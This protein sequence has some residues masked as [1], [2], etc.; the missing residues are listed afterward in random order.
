MLLAAFCAAG[1]SQ[2]DVPAGTT[3]TVAFVGSEVCADCHEQAYSAWQGSH[4]QL[5]MQA[6]T[7]ATVRG[8]FDDAEVQYFGETARFYR[9]DGKFFV[10]AQDASGNPGE[11]EVRWVFGLYPLEQYLVEFPGGRLQA[12]PWAWDTRSGDDGGQRWFHL[13]PDEYIEPG[14]LLHWTGQQQNWNYMCAECHS[15]DVRMNYDV[16]ADAFDTTYSEVSVGCEACHGPGSVHVAEA[17]GGEFRNSRKGLQVNLDDQGRAE[18]IID[19]A[20]GIARRSEPAMRPPQQP[21]TCGRCHSRRSFLT[22]DYHFGEPLTDTHMPAL[23]EDGLYYAD[24]QILDEV[25]V[26]GSFLQSRMYRAGVTC[27]NCHE[28]HSAMLKTGP[29]PNAVCSQCHLPTEFAVAAHTGHEPGVAGCVDCHMPETTYMVVDDRRDHGFRV[30]RPDLTE[31]FGVPNACA[32]CH[33]DRSA[34]WASAALRELHGGTARPEFASAIHAGRNGAG[35]A[36]ILAALASS[37]TPGIARGTL[38]ELLAPPFGDAEI[39]ALRDAIDDPDPL[40]RLAASRVL[41]FLPPEFRVQYG[42]G[43]LADDV[44]AVRLEAVMAYADIA[45]TLPPAARQSFAEA[46]DE[47]RASHHAQL[48]RAEA[49]TSLGDFAIASSDFDLG[50][51]HYERALEIEPRLARVYVN[52][53]D[54][55]RR[56]GDDERGRNILETG[57]E[58]V[59]ES[60]ALYHSLGL[61]L[62]RQ[63]DPSAA[64]A[65][66]RRAVD[67]EPGNSRYAYVLEIAESELGETLPDQP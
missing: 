12:L 47:F 2:S 4:H 1:C 35:N 50:L 54:A 26:Y 57:I 20:T 45:D 66:L 53:A 27:S 59:P 30:P 13:Y 10:T 23:L 22:A 31:A 33:E 63:D 62:V 17:R 58:H 52:M 39:G 64:L 28:P 24:G 40:V 65:A 41:R 29:D 3:S 25:Y 49:W 43:L 37:S 8:N 14:D 46:A 15:T 9:R 61:L 44:L 42:T 21:E 6:A 5:A 56:L 38:L 11:F 7:S 32:D 16:T 48:N 60:A 55:L 36:S 51:Q 34:D 19:P 67:L 18:W